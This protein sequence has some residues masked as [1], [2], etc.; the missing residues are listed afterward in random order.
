M[1]FQFKKKEKMREKKAVKEKKSKKPS[2][3]KVSKL[4]DGNRLRKATRRPLFWIL[5]AIIGVSIFG[6]ISSS[7]N[8]FTKADTSAVLAAISNND[9]ES[10]ILVDR[11]QL[12]RAILKPGKAINGATKVEASYVTRQEPLI[13]ELL[14]SNP[15]PS[16]WN[17]KVPTIVGYHDTR[18]NFAYPLYPSA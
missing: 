15:P 13:V 11:E 4:P 16:N 3:K 18:V 12:I 6:Q 17:V 8:Q 2:N 1:L 14:T 5:L 9:V 7:G 10:A